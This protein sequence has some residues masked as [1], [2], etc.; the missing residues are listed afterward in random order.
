[1]LCCSGGS[2]GTVFGSVTHSVYLVKD[3]NADLEI[4]HC[5]A[6]AERSVN[7]HF[8]AIASVGVINDATSP[9]S[10]AHCGGQRQP[11]SSPPR[12]GTGTG[13]GRCAA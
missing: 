12:R 13:R 7:T 10:A 9:P 4:A 8:I 6:P 5:T 11:A 1:M 3:N 2:M